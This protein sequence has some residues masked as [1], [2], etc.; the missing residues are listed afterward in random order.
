MILNYSS[1]Y[2][3]HLIQVKTIEMFVN[4]G[5][6]VAL[7]CGMD[8]VVDEMFGYFTDCI[9]FLDNPIPIGGVIQIL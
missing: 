5:Q 9:F 3:I 1:H 2:L 6:Y 8:R 4:V 7:L